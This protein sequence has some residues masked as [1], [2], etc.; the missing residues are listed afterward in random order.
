MEGVKRDAAGKIGHAASTRAIRDL[1]G[2]L[3]TGYDD[4]LQRWHQHFHGVL[5]VRSSYDV[6]VMNAVSDE[7][8][9]RSEL[10]DPPTEEE[11][12]EAMGK[13]KLGKAGG[14][15][16]ILPEM[17]RGCGGELMDYILDMF[18]TVWMEQRVPQE[19]RDA[20]LVPIPKKGDLT[21]CDNWRGI[22]LLDVV[23]KLFTKVVQV[24]LQRVAEEVLPDS[25][26][27]FRAGRGCADM[28]FCTRQLVEKAREHNTTLYLLFVDLR[29]A[30]D[31][32]PREALWQVLRKYGVPPSL[33]T[34]IRSPLHDG[35][36][37]EVTVDGAIT[38]EI[39]V[40][41]GLRQGCTIAPTLFNLYFNLVMGQWR[42][43]CHSFGT[44]VHYK[45]GGKLVGERTRRPL[46][47][48][49]TELQFADD[50]ALVCS[51][52]EGVERS[53]RA[54][55][56]VASEWGLT[57]SLQ[58]TKLMVAGTWSEEDLQ[59]IV[60]RAD[61]I[62]VVPEFR[63]LGSIVEMHGEVLKDVEDKIAR[64]SRAF[65]VLCRPVLQDKGLS[66]KTKKMVYRA[67]VM[68]VLLY[69]AEAWVNK[70]AATRKLEAFNN[71]CLRHILGITKA[72]QR[73][74]R[75][76]SAEV[77]RKFGVDEVIEDV[78]VA[79]RLRC[80]GHVVRMD[81]FR[82]PKRILFVWLPQRRPA[83]G[84]KQRWRDKVRKD[85]KQFGI[86]ESSWFHKVQDRLYWRAV[87]KE[88][89]TAC[90]EERQRKRRIAHGCGPHAAADAPTPAAPLLVPH[91]FQDIQEEARHC[92]TQ[93]PDNSATNFSYESA[94]CCLIP[95]CHIVAEKH[96]LYQ[97]AFFQGSRFKVCV[98]VCVRACVRV[99]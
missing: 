50:A 53:A 22:S 81:D 26:C 13:L 93:V 69:G 2:K 88:G 17:V 68:G 34:I 46:K 47:T 45:C 8:P 36:K 61:S 85:L 52:R 74:G 73:V 66:L 51:S 5:N 97:V 7:Y 44:E 18:H 79:K 94:K 65:G 84:T 90:T 89:L 16:G 42:T 29:K 40:T 96:H 43:R 71:K 67:V 31:S 54:L 56:Q 83:H 92:K 77:R 57:L 24:R 30:Y 23:G 39:E 63:Y 14:K 80:L 4:T 21:Q 41:N 82:L 32:V 1:D 19:W 55:D 58:K 27:G 38:P 35:I 11:V 86:D 64:A 3:C 15:S 72:Q 6:G 25:Q 99:W 98:C 62:E 87:C 10:A 75:I 28:V 76:T 60:I 95:V 12:M 70:R 78:M 48:T 9:V 59:P 49:V 91:L 20:L 37:A 33:V